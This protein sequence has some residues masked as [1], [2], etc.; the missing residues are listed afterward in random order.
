MSFKSSSRISEL[1]I[2]SLVLRSSLFSKAGSALLFFFVLCFGSAVFLT[3]ACFFG[4]GFEVKGSTF[5]SNEFSNCC[6]NL[7][8]FLG[9][10]F[11]L[12]TGLMTLLK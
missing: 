12:S 8:G 11:F 3:G 1:S 5:G 10:A 4:C 7:T 6:S 2:F 9:A